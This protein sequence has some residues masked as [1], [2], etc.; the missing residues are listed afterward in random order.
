MPSN[1][2]ADVEVGGLSADALDAIRPLAWRHGFRHAN[3]DVVHFAVGHGDTGSIAVIC[4]RHNGLPARPLDATKKP[5]RAEKQSRVSST[6][7]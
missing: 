6:G 7:G 3:S 1:D 5:S 2:L 4:D